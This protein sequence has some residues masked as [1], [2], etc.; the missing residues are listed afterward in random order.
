M[1][2]DLEI[3]F[4]DVFAPK[5]GE[6]VTIMYD[7]P[8]EIIRAAGMDQVHLSVDMEIIPLKS[9]SDLSQQP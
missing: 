8:H 1:A 3:L 4:V 2:F 7:L 9:V 6:V 5:P